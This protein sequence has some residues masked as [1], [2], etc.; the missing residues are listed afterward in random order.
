MQTRSATA[1]L[2]PAGL[3]GLDASW[4]RLMTTA[5]HRGIER[6]WHVLDTGGRE[7]VHG[8]VLCVHGNPNWSYM[9]RGLA[10]ALTGWRVVAVDALNMGYSERTGTPRLLGDHI[11]DLESVTAALGIDGSVVTVAHDWGGPISLGWAQRHRNQVSGIVLMNTGVARPPG[12]SVPP[13]ISAARSTLRATCVRTPVFLHGAL[14]M[15]RPSLPREV[16]RAYAAPY[17]SAEWRAGIGDFVADIPIDE[18]H[19]SFATLAQVAAGLEQ[20]QTVPA[21]LLWGAKDMIFSDAFL[22]DMIERLPDAD[23]H[24][25]ADAGH[26]II[27]D[28]DAV[29][30]IET[31]LG[32]VAAAPPHELGPGSTPRGDASCEVPRIWSAIE[33]RRGDGAAAI[34]EM[35]ASDPTRVACS[36][37]FAELAG[38]IQAMV[39]ALGEAG[40]A[41]GDRL[42][43][44]VP[45]GIDLTVLVYA[46]LRAGIVVV[47]PDAALGLDGLRRALRSSRPDHVVGDRRALLLAAALR[48]PAN[49]LPL[50]RLAA[51]ALAAS[52][53]T[54]ADSPTPAP[55]RD[56]A[57]AIV[58]TSGS[59]GPSKGVVYT[60]RRLEH[61]R[62]AVRAAF[63]IDER[64]R[65][66]V[67]FA[68]FAVLA[69]ALGIPSVVPTM[70]VTA[71]GEL[72][73]R[74]LAGAAA[75]IDATIVFASPAA[76]A[77]VAATSEDLDQ[78][79]RHALAA[80]R[81]VATAGAPVSPRLLD[82][83]QPVF[84]A[85]HIFTPYGMTEVMPVTVASTDEIR[86]G[87]DCADSRDEQPGVCVGRP[88]CSV[89]VS[90]RPIDEP[91][92]AEVAVG[93]LGEIWVRAAHGSG[94]YDRLWAKSRHAFV[95]GWHRSGDVGHLDP[96]GRLWIEGR[97]DHLIRSAAGVLSPVPIELGAESV[98]GVAR[99]AAVGIGPTGTQQVAVV[100]AGEFGRSGVVVDSAL[101]AAVRDAVS[102]EVAAVLVRPKIPVDRRHNSKVDRGAV[103][104]W[105]EAVLRGDTALRRWRKSLLR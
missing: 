6:T 71:P 105:A 35:Q 99:A 78:R 34:I 58:F 102:V 49:R 31:W 88:L 46:C 97:V 45:P 55:G 82:E 101:A 43:T 1:R 52:G 53:R 89:E 14:R 18:S 98:E 50:N 23:V 68:P 61:Q 90:V 32:A 104:R 91:T 54:T 75:A 47:A 30:V 20:L 103:R 44:L 69:P 28:T 79:G 81:S 64:D 41:Q 9:W 19:E 37:S 27:E 15:A 21:L 36:I 4:S 74:A 87:A 72:G 22:H 48:L 12:V 86:A 93:E 85:A 95:A 24:R 67:A 33:A 3:A 80:I 11:A 92:E 70:K 83:A 66:V 96:Q 94:G 77:N 100:V 13:L 26:Q 76:L 56:D 25:Y 29:R 63:D 65:L 60:H 8:T 51:S 62:D 42:A 5:D 59:T 16:Y 39:H 84:P 2:P 38:R 7:S 10:Q 40:V 73:A 17:G 57:A